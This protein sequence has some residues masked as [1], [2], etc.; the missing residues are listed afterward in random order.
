MKRG[1]TSSRI[2]GRCSTPTP[3]VKGRP[4]RL[5]PI[6]IPPVPCLQRH[7][8]TSA[9]TQ[10]ESRPTKPSLGKGYYLSSSGAR[11]RLFHRRGIRVLYPP[12][13]FLLDRLEFC[14]HAVAPGLPLEQEV[15]PSATAADESQKTFFELPLNLL[16]Q[17]VH[18]VRLG[19]FRGQW[20]E[21]FQRAPVRLDRK[22]REKPD[23][24][25]L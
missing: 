24:G 16:Q 5:G 4:I 2:W 14:L 25:F 7:S 18:F 17:N 9:H 3:I 6:S 15:A 11:L 10:A 12:S 23:V 20:K 22:F 1:E 19:M 21:L 8:G 13:Q